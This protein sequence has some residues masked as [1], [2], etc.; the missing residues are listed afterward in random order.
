MCCIV[1]ECGISKQC[2]LCSLS[3]NYCLQ[4]G[5]PQLN[6]PLPNVILCVCVCV[7]ACLQNVF[8]L[9]FVQCCRTLQ[10]D[11]NMIR[12]INALQVTL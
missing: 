11:D 6:D 3:A 2:G 8:N 7:C 5:M 10:V 9:L 4:E 12:N 1:G